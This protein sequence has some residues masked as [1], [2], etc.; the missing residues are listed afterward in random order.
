MPDPRSP[1]PFEIIEKGRAFLNE[2]AKADRASAG[3]VCR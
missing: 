1:V 3:L 2:H